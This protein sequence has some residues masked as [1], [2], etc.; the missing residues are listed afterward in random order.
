MCLEPFYSTFNMFLCFFWRKDVQNQNKK[1]AEKYTLEEY[2][3]FVDGYR[4]LKLWKLEKSQKYLTKCGTTEKLYGSA[5]DR[6]TI[7]LKRKLV[8]I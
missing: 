8:Q 3:R 7:L 2:R 4:R 1:V 6:W 5:I